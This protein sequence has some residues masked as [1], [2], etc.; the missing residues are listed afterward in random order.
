MRNKNTI[1]VQEKLNLSLNL[2]AFLITKGSYSK[3]VKIL[4]FM[5]E[6]DS[7]YQKEMGREWLVRK[8]MIIQR[9]QRGKVGGR[10][11]ISEQELENFI[12]SEEG[13]TK[14]VEEY[15]IQQILISIPAKAKEEKISEAKN[16][17]RNILQTIR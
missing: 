6:P 4:N 10:V 12:N 16:Q 8:E 13:R 14:L 3:A 2:A 5:S 11:E 9:V 1:S 15:N 17:A 7:Y